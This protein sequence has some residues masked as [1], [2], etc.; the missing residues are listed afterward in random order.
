[1]EGPGGYQFVGR[2]VQMWNRYRQTRDFRDGKQW[3]LRFFDQIRFYPVGKEQLVQMR[4]DFLQGGFN[5][6][7]ENTVLKL[8]DYN[9]FL[10]DHIHQ[11]HLTHLQELDSELQ[12]WGHH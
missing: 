11:F 6:K 8:R 2:T 10:L 9:H 1:M 7:I 3:L 4:A 5:L 12:L